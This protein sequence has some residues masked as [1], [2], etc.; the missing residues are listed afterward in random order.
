MKSNRENIVYQYLR[1]G[2]GPGNGAEGTLGRKE[3]IC[4][5]RNRENKCAFDLEERYSLSHQDASSRIRTKYLKCK[6]VH[7]KKKK[8]LRIKKCV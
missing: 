2:R 8:K 6:S 1:N 4:M 5:K 3:S 7:S